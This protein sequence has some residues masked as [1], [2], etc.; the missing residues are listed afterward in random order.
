M[1]IAHKSPS[2]MGYRIIVRTPNLSINEYTP[3]ELQISNDL[4]EKTGYKSDKNVN[5]INTSFFSSYDPNI[6]HNS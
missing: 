6:Y 2:G 5:N 1:W 3:I 4:F